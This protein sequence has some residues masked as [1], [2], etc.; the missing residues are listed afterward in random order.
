MAVEE[1][2]KG[3][4]NSGEKREISGGPV[5]IKRLKAT[6]EEQ[7]RWDGV[8]DDDKTRHMRASPIVPK[9]IIGR[10]KSFRSKWLKNVGSVFIG[11]LQ[12]TVSKV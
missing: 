2:C 8:N 12:W 10:S 3:T 1:A 5:S 7:N 6:H 11:F 4:S 9:I